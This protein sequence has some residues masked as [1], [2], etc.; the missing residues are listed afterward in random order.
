MRIRWDS[1]PVV[2]NRLGVDQKTVRNWADAGF[3]ESRRDGPRL[4]FVKVFDEG[5]LEGRPVGIDE[6]RAA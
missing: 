1:V 3:I 4:R 2:A 5:P 6:E